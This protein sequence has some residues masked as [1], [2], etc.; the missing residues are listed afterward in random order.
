[1]T[2]SVITIKTCLKSIKSVLADIDDSLI[3]QNQIDIADNTEAISVYSA[4][5][6]ISYYFNQLYPDTDPYIINHENSLTNTITPFDL[7][8]LL[9][10]VLEYYINNPTNH[11]KIVS[12]TH[13]VLSS[14][15]LTDTGDVWSCGTNQYGQLGRTVAN[16]TANIN[17]LGKIPDLPPVAKIFANKYNPSLTTESDPIIFFLCKNNKIYSSGRNTYGQLGHSTLDYSQSIN[18]NISSLQEVIF[19]DL[20][21]NEYIID[22]CSSFDSTYFLTSTKQAYVCGNN[23]YG[24]LGISTI[25]SG[26]YTSNN[27]TRLPDFE[28]TIKQIVVKNTFAFC[29]LD[30]GDVYSCGE[31]YF[32]VLGR[33]EANHGTSTINFFGKITRISNIQKIII[34]ISPSKYTIIIFIDNNKD[35]YT[36]G[37]Y[38]TGALGQNTTIASTYLDPTADTLGKVE[39]SNI[40]DV[41]S[42]INS[43]YFILENNDIYSCG[44]N[45]YGILGRDEYYQYPLNNLAKMNFNNEVITK[46]YCVRAVMWFLT[47]NNELWSCGINDYGQSGHITPIFNYA[48]TYNTYFSTLQKVES[49]TNIK[50]NNYSENLLLSEKMAIFLTNDHKAYVCGKNWY[51]ELGFPY[52]PNGSETFTNVTLLDNIDNIKT[53]TVTNY[54]STFFLTNDGKVYSCGYNQNGELGRNTYSTKTELKEIIFEENTSLSELKFYIST[55]ELSNFYLGMDYI[56]ARIS[57][58]L[59]FYHYIFN[60]TPILLEAD[61]IPILTQGKTY[62]IEVQY[63]PIDQTELRKRSFIDLLNMRPVGFEVIPSNYINTLGVVRNPFAFSGTISNKSSQLHVQLLSSPIAEISDITNIKFAHPNDVIEYEESYPITINNINQ[64]EITILEQTDFINISSSNSK[65]QKIINETIDKITIIKHTMNNNNQNDIQF[66]LNLGNLY[67]KSSLSVYIN[68]TTHFVLNKPNTDINLKYQYLLTTLSKV[69]SDSTVYYTQIP[70]F[71][72][73]TDNYRSVSGKY[74]TTLT[75]G[76]PTSSTK[77]ITVDLYNTFIQ[78]S[79]YHPTTFIIGNGINNWYDKIYIDWGDDTSTQYTSYITNNISHTYTNTNAQVIGIWVNIPSSAN[80]STWQFLLGGNTSPNVSRTATINITIKS[81]ILLYNFSY[82]MAYTSCYV[83]NF[84]SN[85]FSSYLTTTSLKYNI[86]NCSY[87]YY[88][89]IKLR[90]INYFV[91]ESTFNNTLTINCNYMFNNCT[92]LIYIEYSFKNAMNSS[93]TSQITYTFTKAFENCTQWIYPSYQSFN[94]YKSYTYKPYVYATI[95]AAWK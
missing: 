42:N 4:A 25:T 12:I 18:Y 30:N 14:F 22:I 32:G 54:S 53:V 40:K 15:F 74:T 89:C 23:Q 84:G 72:R 64:S 21:L 86:I 87:M 71:L 85:M 80:M 93:A 69:V 5:E 37:Y 28:T 58:D 10:Q 94:D 91:N 61:H 56:Y 77:T 24:Q 68:N 76:D 52:I 48:N 88:H 60:V 79:V 26:S 43:T 83:T 62:Y 50:D 41:I 16:G 17:N 6:I 7:N 95:P 20:L 27:L 65:R 8:S 1:M 36:A 59:L 11:V 67:D 92:D 73:L 9:D 39:L 33:L 51:G 13:L 44:T 31:D 82:L 34:D 29:L 19:P 55:Y 38:Y 3:S 81:D 2:A 49:M 35:C 46:I 45:S 66:Y 90:H 47:E 70:H 57:S 78:I 63:N 75:T